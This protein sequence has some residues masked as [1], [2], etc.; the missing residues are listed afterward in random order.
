MLK[1]IGVG[2]IKLEND[3]NIS[4]FKGKIE[5]KIG[6]DSL[7]NE[8]AEYLQLDNLNFLLGAGCSSHIENDIEYGIP[9]MAN[10]YKGFFK[11]YPD[12]KIAGIAAEPIFNGNLEEMLEVMGAI[13]VAGKVNMIDRLTYLQTGNALVF[14]S[15][16]NLPTLTKFEQADPTTDSDNAKISEKWYHE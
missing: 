15:A 12:F 14:G 8:M 13:A 10:L 7:K 2:G 6:I 5:T 3:K 1:V 16:I 11:E 4:Y 9:G